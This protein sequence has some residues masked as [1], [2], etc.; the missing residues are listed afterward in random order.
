METWHVDRSRAP[1]DVVDQTYP[2]IGAAS[3]HYRKT[4]PVTSGQ[5]IPMVESAIQCYPDLVRRAAAMRP[6]A[7]ALL[8]DGR[9]RTYGELLTNGQR[10]ARLISNLGLQSGERLGLLL[11][12]SVDLA[13]ILLGAS[14]LGVPVVPINTRFRA[15]EIA[16]V[17]ADSAMSAL[18]TC[19]GIADIVDFPALLAEALP[20]LHASADRSRLALA[21]AP[22]LRTIVTL[23]RSSKGIISCLELDESETLPAF[24][25]TPNHAL[26]VLYTSGTSARPK[27][28]VVAHHAIV[29]N[30]LAIRDRYSI[31]SEDVWWCPLPM[32][33]I[34]GIVFIS[35]IFAAAGF[36]VGMSHFTPEAT[37]DLLERVR[38]TVFYPL[39]PT[40]TLAL[41][42]HPRFAAVSK[43]CI[44]FV[45]S[46]AP[47]GVQKMIQAAF[48]HAVLLSAFGM[49]ET[50]GVVTFNLP[51]DDESLRFETCGVP[52]PGWQVSILD[53]ATRAP[54]PPG[55]RGEIAVRGPGLFDGYFGHPELALRQT[56][57]DGYFLTGD[58]GVVDASGYLSYLGRLKD[59][60]KVGG[61][62]VSALEIESFLATHPAVNLAQVVSL[63]DQKYGE[64]PV[65]FVELKS[66]ARATERELI[67]YCTGK[68]AR[69]KIP[70]YVRFVDTWPMSATKILKYQLRDRIASEFGSTKK[71]PV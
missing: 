10:W 22:H 4:T 6:D 56:T 37:F 26:L 3:E 7:K 15:Y 38:P 54:L 48:P 45:F 21:A 58:L 65:A 1:I 44:R 14:M 51:A 39:F 43:D 41:I 64:V 19:D 17:I 66:G 36:Y 67:D 40:I 68:I 27:G 29:A 46:V 71:A 25:V 52:L 24:T 70:R 42:E 31:S 16:H 57:S 55:E 12:N 59:Q 53:P 2:T 34:G 13:E 23:G 47:P 28:C 62:N 60:L 61:E 20:G 18:V 5:G 30:A 49:T 63:S 50:C 8:I 69:F 35:V 11:P 9:Q 33:H 32:F